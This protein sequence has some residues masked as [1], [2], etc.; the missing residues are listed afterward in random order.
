MRADDHHR[1]MFAHAP[2]GSSLPPHH[3]IGTTFVLVVALLLAGVA[4]TS[5]AQPHA[6]TATAG[7]GA[8]SAPARQRPRVGL[9]LSGGGAR[10]LAHVGVLK[11]LERERIAVDVIA[12][13][14]MGAIVGG[15]YA[16]GMSA[17]DLERELLQINWN[18]TF[19]R[20]VDRTELSQRRKDED[21]QVQQQLEF[22]IRDGEVRFPT[23]AASSRALELMLRRFTLPV[24]SIERFDDLPIPF[25]AVA[26]DLETGQQVILDRGD[27]A[28]AMRSSMSVP[29]VFAPTEVDGRLLGDGMLVE[30]L[31]VSVAQAMGA[32]VLIVV[33]IGT[34]LAPR[35]SLGTAVGVTVQ[36][37]NILT[38]QNVQRS[39]A[40]MEADDVLIVPEL[41]SLGSGDFDKAVELVRLGAA[42]ADAVVTRLA[43][44]ALPPSA[45]ADWR[46]SHRTRQAPPVVIDRVAFEG[47]GYS[48][49]ARFQSELE[50]KPG[51]PFD[52]D[53]AERDA[54]RLA[55]TGD[56]LR[57]DYRISRDGG[58]EALV[59]ELAEK[60]WGPDFLRLGLS[61]Y[62]D[63]EGDSDFNLR[64]AHTRHWLNAGGAEWRNVIQIGEEPMLTSELYYPLDVNLALSN[65]WFVSPYVSLSRRTVTVY[66]DDIP[67]LS[68]VNYRNDTQML[69]VDLG[70][71]WGSLGELRLGL[72]ATRY[73]NEPSNVLAEV[74]DRVAPQ[75]F[76]DVGGLIRFRSDQLDFAYFPTRGFRFEA[77]GG[78][79]QRTGTLVT[80]DYRGRYYQ[81]GLEGLGVTTFGR[82]TFDLLAVAK[83]MSADSLDLV[84]IY[85]LGGF[86]R[87]SGYLLNQLNGNA[88][89]F[90][91]LGWRTQVAGE[92]FISRPLMV[93]ATAEAG[94]TWL[95]PAEASLS[96]LRLG[97]SLYIGADSAIGPV[98]LGLTYAPRGQF[99][100]VFTL[101]RPYEI[102]RF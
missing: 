34:S 41:G 59:F 84:G 98:H 4:A 89:V 27:L 54:A 70:R 75:R 38:E 69:G 8:A 65:D 76:T 52:P 17:D 28:L 85:P 12:G 53:K 5:H 23:S 21:Y 9:V 51:E 46:Q 26:T 25:R 15:L 72:R 61:L 64:L 93:G 68:L 91:R 71:P 42:G 99:G 35:E 40:A 2:A 94:N 22:G 39:L 32:D 86:Q 1:P 63:F 50:S 18:E 10:G 55:A 47:V 73:D 19:A 87:L 7:D 60:P 80:G 81:V 88:L 96:D 6:P 11:V 3:R 66:S 33:N 16:S 101:G 92:T 67:V 13:T 90:T 45:Y 95:D 48:N 100:I 97:T 56:Y 83:G 43:S 82:H 31:P 20:R 79:G 102:G 30:N 29:G 74:I 78:G 77:S 24:R 36:M 49:P 44:L 37:L 58:S 14:S 57:T 62:T